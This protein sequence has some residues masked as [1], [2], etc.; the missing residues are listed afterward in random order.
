MWI[1]IGTAGAVIGL[2]GLI[3]KS[4]SGRIDRMEEGLKGKINI[5]MCT[6]RY[7]ELKEDLNKGSVRFDQ[8]ISEQ[9]KIR[10]ILA[11]LDERI[12]VL[13]DRS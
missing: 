3:V 4:Q 9:A 5:N 2:I 10:V 11:R 7:Q 12:K 8:L 6:T 1:E 13:L